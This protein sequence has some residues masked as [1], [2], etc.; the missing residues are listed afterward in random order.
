MQ[1]KF[2]LKIINRFDQEKLIANNI[3][4]K[5]TCIL[6]ALFVMINHNTDQDGH[7]Y[8]KTLIIDGVTYYDFNQWDIINAIP[9]C[10]Y[11]S[12]RQL[13][14]DLAPLIQKGFIIKYPINT[15]FL[16]RLNLEPLYP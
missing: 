14:R 7:E 10:G 5:Q 1:Q 9:L 12:K 4:L 15:K 16:I 11:N 8:R 6:N 3:N 13:Q 2:K